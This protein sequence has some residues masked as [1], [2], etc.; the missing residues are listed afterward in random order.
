MAP[1]KNYTP[2]INQS[3]DS[4][5]VWKNAAQSV[6]QALATE[7][8]HK[9]G[10]V[11]MQHEADLQK[12]LVDAQLTQQLVRDGLEAPF[13]LREIEKAVFD[14]GAA[15]V[16]AETPEAKA[17][18]LSGYVLPVT[19]ALRSAF[20]EFN[21]TDAPTQ[22]FGGRTNIPKPGEENF[23]GRLL[24][25]GTTPAPNGGRRAIDDPNVMGRLASSLRAND[26]QEVALQKAFASGPSVAPG[27]GSGRTSAPLVEGETASDAQTDTLVSAGEPAE[28]ADDNYYLPRDQ[29]VQAAEA[30]NVNDRKMNPAIKVV[31]FEVPEVYRRWAR[32]NGITD[33]YLQQAWQAG[34]NATLQ[35]RADKALQLHK[36]GWDKAF[37]IQEKG[38]ERTTEEMKENAAT[39]R[40]MLELWGMTMRGSGGSGPDPKVPHWAALQFLL[41]ETG[42]NNQRAHELRLA[43]IREGGSNYRQVIKMYNDNLEKSIPSQQ[44][45]GF[46]ALVMPDKAEQLYKSWEIQRRNAINAMALELNQG[47]PQADRA[48][49]LPDDMSKLDKDIP[50]SV[51]M[52]L[53]HKDAMR[54][55][56]HH[57]NGTGTEESAAMS[58]AQTL[59]LTAD[60]TGLDVSDI[61]RYAGLNYQYGS[62]AQ[63]VPGANEPRGRAMT[64]DDWIARARQYGISPLAAQV[65][66][67]INSGE[68]DFRGATGD[69]ARRRA[70]R[71]ALVKANMLTNNEEQDAAIVERLVN[72]T[73]KLIQMTSS[74]Q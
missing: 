10:L 8:D 52:D 26:P 61:Q 46:L 69:E 66:H 73:K 65:I 29:M 1:P 6:S 71:H 41:D 54:L 4:S 55:S 70:A 38:L 36:E 31:D 5:W 23:L 43:Q 24:Q 57:L 15:A 16:E 20:D 42:K 56:L 13:K 64:V 47:L 74:G 35:G 19:Q 7:A 30:I 39:F 50:V 51:L 59:K 37:G 11:R 48:A 18:I 9:M 58:A 25:A 67:H 49:G 53:V 27:T 45:V 22:Y 32:R 72:E 63:P 44:N 62:V 14:L 60:L 2:K 33:R 3:Y 28:G 40:K 12:L 17:A 21:K 34:R 68:V